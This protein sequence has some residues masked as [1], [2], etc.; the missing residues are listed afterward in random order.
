MAM[1]QPSAANLRQISA[2][3]PLNG[4]VRFIQE[5]EAKDR[6]KTIEGTI[7]ESFLNEIGQ[8]K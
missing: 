2:P 3:R 6:L 7:T 5:P 4:G 8:E 1:L